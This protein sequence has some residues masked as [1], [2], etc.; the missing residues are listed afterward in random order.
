MKWSY[1]AHAASRRCQRL[2]AFSYLVASHAA[3]DAVRR[4]AYILKQLQHVAT[5]QGSLVHHVLA[6]EFVPAL[7][8]RRPVGADALAASARSLAE[9]QFAFSAAKRYRDPAETKA[10]AGADYCALFEH[11]FDLANQTNAPSRVA[12][13]AAVSFK[14]LMSQT[15]FMSQLRAGSGHVAEMPLIFRLDG[16]AV[17]ATPDLICRFVSG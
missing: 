5:W 10:R 2:F 4:E 15:E 16:V 13:D 3:R 1:S 8:S 9:R 17:T 6:T 7:R 14:N 12:D 11:E